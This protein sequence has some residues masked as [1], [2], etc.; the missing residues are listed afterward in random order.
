MQNDEFK[1]STSDLFILQTE[2]NAY[3]KTI[4]D[5]LI[6]TNKLDKDEVQEKLSQNR[7][8]FHK[9]LLAMQNVK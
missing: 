9:A 6:E 8:L 2:T 3:L 5:T 7:E 4:L 1:V